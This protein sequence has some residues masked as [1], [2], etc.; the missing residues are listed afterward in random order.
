MWSKDR[1]QNIS[2]ARRMKFSITYDT[3]I[4]LFNLLR[5]PV[6]MYSITLIRAGKENESTT[7]F[8]LLGSNSISSFHSSSMLHTSTRKCRNF[9]KNIATVRHMRSDR[10]EVSLVLYNLIVVHELWFFTN[11]LQFVLVFLLEVAFW[12]NNTET[13]SFKFTATQ[14]NINNIYPVIVYNLCIN[15]NLLFRI[16]GVS[17]SIILKY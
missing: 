14:Y 12:S 4:Y 8:R 6:S 9:Q 11:Q 13:T 3:I 17:C 16:R 15:K 1:V 7:S 2:L 5:V 10:T